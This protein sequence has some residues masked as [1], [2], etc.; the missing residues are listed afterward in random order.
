M[1]IGQVSKQTNLSKDTIRF[2]E[3]LGLIKVPKTTSEFNNYK[4][5]T[6]EH[7]LR[8][9]LIKKVKRF[10]FT[11][12]EIAELLQL[13]DQQSANCNLLKK[14]VNEKIIDIDRKILELQNMKNFI[15]DELKKAQRQCS[16]TSNQSNCELMS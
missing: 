5:Y 2:Y 6:Q 12:N 1:L 15:T 7:M 3:K 9:L 10:G 14:K 4:H 13:K 11:L 16:G 8:L